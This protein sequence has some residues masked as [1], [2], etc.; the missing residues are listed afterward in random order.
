MSTYIYKVSRCV[1]VY[2]YTYYI[3]I[4]YIDTDKEGEIYFQELTYRIVGPVSLKSTWQVGR[5]AIASGVEVVIL[6]KAV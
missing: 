1:C 2:I 3:Y 4:V 6:R 5:L